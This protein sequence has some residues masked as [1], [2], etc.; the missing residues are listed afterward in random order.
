MQ[1]EVANP[2]AN[3][4]TEEAS[5]RRVLLVDPV[6]GTSVERM[7]SAQGYDVFRAA[8]A[9]TAADT[10]RLVG[11]SPVVVLNMALPDQAGASALCAIRAVD[12]C[13]SVVAYGVVDASSLR[14]VV[15][16]LPQPV[17][18]KSLS[19]AMHLAHTRRPQVQKPT[20][21]VSKA[22]RSAA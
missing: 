21:T 10:Y 3:Q 15:A 7:L 9:D 16:V 20:T 2:N 12:L 17:E 19:L 4:M 8:D 1:N 14:G 5:A 22:V 11:G 13:A 6:A 18:N